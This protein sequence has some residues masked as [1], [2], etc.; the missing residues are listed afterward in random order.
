MLQLKEV[1]KPIVA[2]RATKTFHFFIQWHLTE[3][4]N[5]RCRHC[6]QG[7]DKPDEMSV[8]AVK[9]EIDGV[10]A[11]LA[12]WEEDYDM[13]ISPSIHFT[14]GEPF[15]YGGLWD[16]VA[17]ARRC[18][19][20]VALLTN[21]ALI[22]GED[23]AMAKNLD[24]TDIQVSLDGP[25]PIHDMIRGSGSFAAAARGVRLLNEAGNTVSANMT[26]SRLNVHCVQATA[27]AARDAG[28]GSL[29]F[30]RL[31]PCGNG[32]TLLDTLLSPEELKDAYAWLLAMNA[33]DF[34]VGS[35]DPLAVM[36]R[37]CGPSPETTLSYS[38][39]SAGFFGV[40]ILSDGSVMP[41]RRI[42]V[43]IGNLRK[44]SLRH[45]WATSKVLEHLRKRDRYKGKCGRCSSWNSCRGCRAVAYAYSQSQGKADLFAD[46]PQCWREESIN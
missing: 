35:G 37:N 23:A 7:Q 18:G 9:R 14:G 39:C 28:F 46:D 44:N 33:P 19:F 25:P 38:G 2:G 13:A 15:M 24:I 1:K 29:G 21:G 12:A 30:S 41:C 16:V 8:D 43:R 22:K 5:L 42:G 10:M 26:L 3:R 34:E 36:Y 40:T 20:K 17:H 11:M 6:Y 45:I 27:K 32:K 31:V 4:C